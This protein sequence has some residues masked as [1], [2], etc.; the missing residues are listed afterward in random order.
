M[1]ALDTNILVRALVQDDPGQTPVAQRLLA[2]AESIYLTK[3]VLMEVEW[4]LRAAYAQPPQA[5]HQALVAL[6]RLPHVAAEQPDELA[7]ALTDFAAGMD[8]A[9]AL[10]LAAAQ[11]VGAEFHTFDAQC[12]KLARRHG[13]SAALAKPRKA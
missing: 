11:T 4:V 13:R 12:A 10:H 8:F 7:Q 2:Q 3:T 5:I 1:I 9:D 6:L